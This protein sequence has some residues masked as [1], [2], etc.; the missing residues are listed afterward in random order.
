MAFGLVLGV[1]VLEAGLQLGA[2]WVRL[3][4]QELPSSWL[5]GSRRI[6]CLGDSNTYGL[7]LPNRAQ[8]Y[9]HRLEAMWNAVGDVPRIEVINLGYPGTN[10]SRIRR[11][12]R[13]MLEE[14]RPDLVAVM[15]GANDSW[16]LRVPVEEPRGLWERGSGFAKRH[17][18]VY[19]LAHMIRR[20]LIAE[21]VQYEDV[22]PVFS[23]RGR[24]TG[25]RATVRIGG[26]EFS[27]GWRTGPVTQL[28]RWKLRSNLW[29][30]A[31]TARAFATPIAFVTYP[32]EQA[33]YGVANEE[34]RSVAGVGSAILVDT[35]PLF[36]QYC[37][38]EPCP[39]FLYGDHHPTAR[40][41]EIVADSVMHRLLHAGPLARNAGQP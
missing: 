18:R 39:E 40:G 19:L 22:Q 20:S 30:I 7:Y 17:S 9:P 8:A 14:L 11:G 27:M 29:A 3:R 1:A 2:L 35:V 38:S 28:H 33:S 32:S 6:L 5:T 21:R 41:H 23:D 24:L 25:E 36:R 4:G 13:R 26:A 37:P 15:V 16:T 10:S 31:E 34:I 12:L